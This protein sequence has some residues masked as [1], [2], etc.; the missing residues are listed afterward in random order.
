MTCWKNEFPLRAL[1]VRN[2]VVVFPTV[3][4]RYS[5]KLNFYAHALLRGDLSVIL[6]DDL[7]AYQNIFRHH[8]RD[9]N[10]LANAVY[11]RNAL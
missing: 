6:W 3:I 4:P 7:F 1:Q 5:I 10:P 11:V 2:S 8:Q 9:K